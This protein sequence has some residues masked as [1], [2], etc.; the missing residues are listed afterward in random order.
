M[1]KWL[2]FCDDV[3]SLHPGQNVH[4]L[5]RP[6]SILW[7]GDSP[8]KLQGR[9]EDWVFRGDHYRLMLRLDN[10]VGFQFQTTSLPARELLK[11][12][13]LIT[14][15]LA[16]DGVICLQNGEAPTDG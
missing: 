8:N 9:V 11:I 7:E 15:A 3:S 6:G 13:D 14:V 10:G 5:V 16:G 12:G 4:V 1:G 2:A